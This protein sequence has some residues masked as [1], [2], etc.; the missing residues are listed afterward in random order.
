MRMLHEIDAASALLYQECR[1]H[2]LLLSREERRHEHDLLY[3]RSH[4]SAE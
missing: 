2:F 4:G 3:A 1:K